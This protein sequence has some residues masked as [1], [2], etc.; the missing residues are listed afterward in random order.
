[1]YGNSCKFFF[2]VYWLF[3]HWGK[4]FINPKT[5][6]CTSLPLF[7]E[8]HAFQCRTTSYMSSARSFKQKHL[9]NIMQIKTRKRY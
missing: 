7:Q 9:R 4:F 3:K 2:L 8:D 1:M 5:S 6:R